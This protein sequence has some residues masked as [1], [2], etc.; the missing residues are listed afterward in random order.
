[1]ADKW[2]N[3]IPILKNHGFG[4]SQ[5]LNPK[6]R[7]PYTLEELRR[8]IPEELAKIELLLP[9]YD[10]KVL[11]D[12]PSEI[13]R[14]YQAWRPTPV[15]RLYALEKLLGT[16]AQIW[17]KDESVSETG[18]HKPNTSFMQVHVAKREGATEEVIISGKTTM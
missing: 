2:Y 16:P 9:P 13:L 18:S 4:L 15:R 8:V 14:I 17:A 5:P 6:T 3:P 11:I 12:I 10:K 1:M 7:K